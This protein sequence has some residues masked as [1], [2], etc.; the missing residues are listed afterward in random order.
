M[1]EYGSMTNLRR[2]AGLSAVAT[3]A[4]VGRLSQGGMP[5]AVYLPLTFLAL[6]FVAGAV[7][8]WGAHAGMPGILTDGRTCARGAA[9]AAGLGLLFAGLRWLGAGAMLRAVR[10]AP[11]A[12]VLL[13]LAHPG[14][15]A[16]KLSLLLWS[17]GVQ[18]LVLV[19]APMSLFARLTRRRWAALALCVAL[20][21]WV[22]N[23]QLAAAAIAAGAGYFQ[24][25]ALLHTAVAGFLFAR[26]G[27]VPALLFASAADLHVF[28]CPPH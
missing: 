17:S 10:Q 11:D 1:R 3:L 4:A 6:L 13:E 20:R 18:T 28:L 15:L 21:A 9:A 23:R 14:T 22:M 2:A 19:A 16:G 25:G 24:A 27:L 26:F 12:A 7:T 5:L 8:A